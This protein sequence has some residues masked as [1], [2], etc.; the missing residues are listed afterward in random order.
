M[1]NQLVI[2]KDPTRGEDHK[3]L[4]STNPMLY[5]DY[6]YRGEDQRSA[7]NLLLVKL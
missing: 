7:M 2:D 1:Y 4:N 6:D 3:V 5:A